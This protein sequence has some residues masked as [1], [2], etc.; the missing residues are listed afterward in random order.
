MSRDETYTPIQCQTVEGLDVAEFT[1]VRPCENTALC[2]G[3]YFSVIVEKSTV[4]CTGN[5]VCS[6]N[7]YDKKKFAHR[8]FLYFLLENDCRYPDQV[9]FMIRPGG[10]TCEVNTRRSNA[11][12]HSFSY[13]SMLG[14]VFMAYIIDKIVPYFSYP[15]FV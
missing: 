12:R 7:F 11:R 2:F 14:L 10:L 5:C 15:T 4:R 1:L 3:L 6:T 8:L 13:V 9:R